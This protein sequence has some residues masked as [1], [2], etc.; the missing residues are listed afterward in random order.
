MDWMTL[1]TMSA[2]LSQRQ[3][4]YGPVLTK[5]TNWGCWYQEVRR[6][7][8]SGVQN[9][10]QQDCNHAGR[11]VLDWWP[12]RPQLLHGY[13]LFSANDLMHFARTPFC[14][15]IIGSNTVS[16]QKILQYSL[17][18]F[19]SHCLVLHSSF[20]GIQSL[21]SNI[22]VLIERHPKI[23]VSH[24]VKDPCILQMC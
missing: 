3:K 12:R 22:C 2:V 7:T 1:F 8:I 17:A 4:S 21:T 18:I 15:D 5:S 20:W 9:G 19:L 24:F 23:I 10:G 6:R 11:Q 16:L 13:F 14:F